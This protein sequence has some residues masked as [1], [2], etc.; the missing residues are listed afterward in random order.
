[1]SLKS[2]FQKIG[3]WFKR[4]FNN[5]KDNVAPVA[6][7]ITQ[8][9]KHSLDN[10]LLPEIAHIF[11]S[12]TGTHIPSDVVAVIAKNINKVL[13]SELALVGLPDNATPEEM[14]AFKETVFKAFTGQTD[15]GRS[16]LFTTLA[17]QIKTDIDQY[18]NDK[19]PD[20]F[21][22]EVALVQKI[23]EQYQ[24]DLANPDLQGDIIPDPKTGA[25]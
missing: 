24:E 13:I 16:K 18:V 6:V 4:T 10:G 3:A 2:F 20:T 1:M 8:A 21:A 15:I 14:V 19:T 23:W 25:Q 22:K 12:I 9:I 7:V 11:D 17:V 5:V